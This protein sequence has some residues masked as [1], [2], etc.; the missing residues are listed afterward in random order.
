MKPSVYGNLIFDKADKNIHWGKESLFNKWC[1]ENWLAT[2]RRANQDPYLSPLTKIQWI[3]EWITDLNLRH[4]TLRILEEDIG[5]TLSDIGLGKELLRK[6]PKTITAASKINKWD[7]IKLKSFCTAKETISRANRQPT[8][9][10]K[11]FALYTSDKGLITRIYLELKRINKKKANNPI[12]K[13]A[14][15]MK[16]NFSKED[17]IMA[18]KHRKTSLIIR[19]TQIK[20]TMR[21]HLTPVRMAYIKKTPNNKCWRG[22]RETGTLLHCWWDCKLVQ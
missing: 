10:E 13:W 5:K 12:K 7:L 17:R 6:T 4:E 11:I 1:W 2:C 9:W 21:Y 14:A 16:R 18:C 8:E 3:T 20:T 15:E 19:E 22:C